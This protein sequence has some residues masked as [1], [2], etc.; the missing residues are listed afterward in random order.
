MPTPSTTL[1]KN[2]LVK[3]QFGH[4]SR[5]AG[6]NFGLNGELFTSVEEAQLLTNRYRH[7]YNQS[8]AHSSLGYLSPHE[9]LA[10]DVRT[11]PMVLTHVTQTRGHN[12]RELLQI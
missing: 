4:K 11:Q 3:A 2:I 1:G 12:G 10:P 5:P 9:F 6:G 7:D 8:R